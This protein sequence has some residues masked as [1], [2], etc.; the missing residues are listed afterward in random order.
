MT[1][2]LGVVLIAVAFAA[3]QAYQHQAELTLAVGK[4]AS[5]EGHTFVYRGMEALNTPGRSSL[6]AKVDLDGRPY[7]PAVESFLLSDEAVG[8]PAV[9]S[10]PAQDIYLSIASTPDSATGPLGLDVYVKPLIMWL[11]TGGSVIVLGALL[12][13]LPTPRRRLR[14]AGPPP[15]GD[16]VVVELPDSEEV[17]ATVGAPS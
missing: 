12:S 16:E 14:P 15:G 13:L 3:S 11:W 2:H 5:F 6:V 4:P 8:S 17:P 7:Y 9:R 1:V 10:T